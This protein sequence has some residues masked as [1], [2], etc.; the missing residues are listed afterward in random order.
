[1]FQFFRDSF[2]DYGC[3]LEIRDVQYFPDGRSVVD[4]V[5]GRRFQVINRG[6][7]EGYNTAKVELLSDHV[8]THPDALA[9]KDSNIFLNGQL[10]LSHFTALEE[11]HNAVRKEAETWVNSLPHLH[12][13]K[14]QQHMGELPN[15][16]ANPLSLADGPAW[17]WWLLS[18]LPLDTRAKL[19]ILAMCSLK[20]RLQAYKRILQYVVRKSKAK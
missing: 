5:G 12:R 7:R 10:I 16:E 11:L 6:M 9:G 18:V 2:S 13:M 15:I 19:S 17:T 14:I 8:E 4:T 1:M 3:I 20:D